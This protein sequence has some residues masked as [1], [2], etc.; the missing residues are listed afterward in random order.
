MK[1]TGII[2]F[3]FADNVGGVLQCLGLYRQIQKMGMEPFVI[4]Y[5]PW[6]HAA[7]Y[8]SWN[9]V[10]YLAWKKQEFLR[11]QRVGL[12]GRIKAGMKMIAGGILGNL[13]FPKNKKR[14]ERFEQFRKAHLSQSR[15]YR[16]L[17]QLQ[18]VPPAYE[19]Y[20][21]GSD[22]IWNI[23][24]TDG[25]FDPAYFLKFGPRE[26]RRIAY[27]VSA[28][29]TD[30]SSV[31]VQYR[32]A[33]RELDTILF[34][35]KKDRETSGKLLGKDSRVVP[36]P[37]FFLT[38]DEWASFESPVR[39]EKPYIFVYTVLKSEKV[40]RL[41]ADLT[42]KH[43][44]NVIDGSVHE[45]MKGNEHYRY[46]PYC[47]PGEFLNYIRNA[48]FV[49][50]NSFH[51]TA[52][53]LI[54]HKNF[55]VICNSK[56]N[57]R[58]Q[59][60][61]KLLGLEDRMVADCVPETVLSV[62][63]PDYTDVEYRLAAER[64]RSSD[65]LLTAMQQEKDT[66]MK[67]EIKA[68]SGYL[69]EPG[70]LVRSSSGGAAWALSRAVIARGGTV[71]GVAYTED[72]RSARYDCAVTEEELEKFRTSKYISA[73][74]NMQ[75]KGEEIS[76]FEA[77]ARELSTGVEVLF[78]GLGCEAGALKQYLAAHHISTEKLYLTDLICF[79]A[80]Y[81]EIQSQYISMLEKR[82][83][84]GITAFT[85]RHKKY[86][87]NP[88]VLRAEF[89]N[90][91]IHEERFYDTDFGH[92]FKV[93]AKA[94]CYHCGFKG[95]NHAADLTIGDYRGCDDSMECYNRYGVSI[96]LS[97]TPK[98][99]EMIRWLKDSGEFRVFDADPATAVRNNPAYQH[100]RSKE[101]GCDRFGSDLKMHGLH[102]AV[103]KDQGLLRYYLTRIKH[104][105]TDLIRH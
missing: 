88:F 40:S 92:A 18:R 84:S 63:E 62:R 56:R 70:Q 99:E 42:T 6:Y 38:G 67:Q 9:P 14:A 79:G 45:Y 61:L 20:I 23:N 47:G 22:Q 58:M 69:T 65:L 86:G 90:G 19:N 35:E 97:G 41:V 8:F 57:E 94:P 102:Y 83:G 75:Y 100:S 49:I 21:C 48:E 91:K 5:R 27:A 15:R 78:T 85:T 73:E 81:P 53:S 103:I 36:D 76:V 95:E 16:S 30:L 12:Q 59:E 87:W 3:H 13:Q 60:I 1:K 51:G 50:T 74:K 32:E 101:A 25:V 77:V 66:G 11:S 34:R 26:T 68:Y 7:K 31:A 82:Y 2:T 37:T 46:D 96:M 104:R 105:L 52:F 44:V 17:R 72:F 29:E 98:G 80:T 43:N 64:E 33:V 54:Y 89:G 93:C 24:L 4:D 39:A 10:F 55:L 71:F 28:G